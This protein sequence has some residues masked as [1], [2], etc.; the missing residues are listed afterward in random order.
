MQMWRYGML[1]FMMMCLS[2]VFVYV[3]PMCLCISRF[4]ID[5][6]HR[7]YVPNHVDTYL[8][9]PPPPASI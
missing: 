1:Y 7:I 8:L 9:S 4:T 2:K 6:M 5:L 3:P